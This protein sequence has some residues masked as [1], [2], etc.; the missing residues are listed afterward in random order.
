MLEER[1]TLVESNIEVQAGEAGKGA[2]SAVGIG[3][4]RQERGYAC[5]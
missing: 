1:E 4:G 5:E 3:V 2:G